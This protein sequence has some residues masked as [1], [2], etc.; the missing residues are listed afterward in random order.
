MRVDPNA[1][2]FIMH[3]DWYRRDE[4]VGYIPTK[5]APEMAKKAMERYNSYTFPGAKKEKVFA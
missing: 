3:S 1:I 2:V 4:N 5:K